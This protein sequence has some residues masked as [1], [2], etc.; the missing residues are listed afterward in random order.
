MCGRR[1]FWF[2]P[3][4]AK[5]A[6]RGLDFSGQGRRLSKRPFYRQVLVPVPVPVPVDG[7]V[8]VPAS[9]NVLSTARR[10]AGGGGSGG[11]AI[12]WVIPSPVPSCSRRNNAEGGGS[13]GR[14][15][16]EDGIGEGGGGS[17]EVDKTPEATRTGRDAGLETAAD[18]G[19]CL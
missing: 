18:R 2:F 15:L 8:G 4:F 13:P 16:R 14:G 19:S 3:S 9:G 5:R 10:Q 1:G 12:G 17:I 6:A 7:N 11:G